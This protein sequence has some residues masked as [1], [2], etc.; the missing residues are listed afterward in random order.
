MESTKGLRA[1]MSGGRGVDMRLRTTNPRSDG[2]SRSVTTMMKGGGADMRSLAHTDQRG[3][4]IR[5]MADAME[6]I[7]IRMDI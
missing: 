7:M 1:E 2:V 6:D 5:K 4:E 3:T